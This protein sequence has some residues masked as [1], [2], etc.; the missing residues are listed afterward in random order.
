MVDKMAE[1]DSTSKG[2]TYKERMM[3]ETRVSRSIATI[4]GGGEKY[5]EHRI[6]ISISAA[7]VAK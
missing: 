7:V 4:V 2:L 3:M 6:G 5:G 1:H